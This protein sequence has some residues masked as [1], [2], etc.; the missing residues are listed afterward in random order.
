MGKLH[1]ETEIKCGDVFIRTNRRRG[2]VPFRLSS[3]FFFIFFAFFILIHNN[4]MLVVV[5]SQK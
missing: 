3:I 4:G 2:R 1:S 5:A